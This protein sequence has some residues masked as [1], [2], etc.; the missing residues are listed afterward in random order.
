MKKILTFLAG[1][2]FIITILV[3]GGC[4][5]ASNNNDPEDKKNVKIYCKAFK[6]NGVLHFEMYDSTDTK[7][8]VANLTKDKLVANHTADVKPGTK[9][10]WSWTNDSEIMEF[11]R[12]G[13]T[14]KG[15]IIDKDAEKISGTKKLR[16]EIPKDAT[17][18]KE[19]YDIV[20]VGWDGDTVTIDPYLKIPD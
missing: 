14:R 7:R 6:E 1:I 15:D 17:E 9:V 4:K 3:A 10:T 2:V 11:V 16:L 5:S 18:G 13:P 19:K 20:F 12:I 8:V